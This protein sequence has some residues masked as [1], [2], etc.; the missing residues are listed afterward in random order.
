M[1]CL[2]PILFWSLIGQLAPSPELTPQ[3][4]IKIVPYRCP[5]DLYRGDN[6]PPLSPTAETYLPL[7]R[8]NLR[9][10]W[11]R[12]RSSSTSSFRCRNFASRTPW[13]WRCSPTRTS[14]ISDCAASSSVPSQAARC[15]WWRRTLLVFRL[16]Q[17]ATSNTTNAKSGRLTKRFRLPISYTQQWINWLPR[18]PKN[19]QLGVARHDK[20]F[21]NNDVIVVVGGGGGAGDET[22]EEANSK[23]SLLLKKRHVLHLLLSIWRRACLWWSARAR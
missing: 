2:T 1:I 12:R 18:L 3:K 7:R 23:S 5:I 6:S 21:P 14:P 11:Q 17:I 13:N 10:T 4:T 9:S 15:K 16:H 22:Q 19:P 8:G 20:A